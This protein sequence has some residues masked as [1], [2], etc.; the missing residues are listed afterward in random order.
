MVEPPFGLLAELTHRCPLRCGYCSNPLELVRRDAEL[1]TG[2]WRSVFDQARAL[3][4]LQFHLSGGEPLARRDLP[5]LVAHASGLGAYVNLVTSGLGLTAE[6]LADLRDRGVDHVQLSV[7]DA[8]RAGAD[9]IAGVK[10][11]GHKL[12]AARAVRD[13]GLPLTV[14][15]VLHRLNLDH[16]GDIIA[17]A[18]R[19]GADRLELANTQYY[20]WALRN[21]AAL[22]PSREQL[23]RAGLV[24]ERA[25][26]RTAMEIVYVIADYHE[27]HPKPCMHG[28]GAR[29]LTVAPNGDVLPCPA[30]TVIEHLPVE[31]ARDRPLRDIWYD[32]RSFNA[33]RG[34][35]WMREPCRSC[36][37]KE[38][39]FGGCRCQAFQLTGDAANTDPVC[40]LSPERG[41]VDAL[42]AA[43]GAP[44]PLVQR[45]AEP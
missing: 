41:R 20:G 28:W 39:D 24:V 34:F 22:L 17:L 21:R 25:R 7:Q 10:S 37:R 44:P 3:G 19:M 31:N 12:A 6:R 1:G 43:E 36:A 9:L 14:N 13:A 30:A 5:E 33:F 32:S 26:S 8:Q 23:R 27:A 40:S 16:V 38:L 35:D 45:R 2:Q 18:E 42:L 4:V 15:A 29:Q 11:F